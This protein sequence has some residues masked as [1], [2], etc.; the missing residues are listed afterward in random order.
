MTYLVIAAVIALLT[1]VFTDMAM[2]APGE[3]RQ[4]D[5]ARRARVHTK[6]HHYKLGSR[7]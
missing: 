2:Y 1:Y 6:S 4:M 5:Q 7:R 3:K